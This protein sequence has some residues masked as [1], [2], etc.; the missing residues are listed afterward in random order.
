MTEYKLFDEIDLP[1]EVA[2]LLIAGMT[3]LITGGLLFPVASGVLPYYENGLYGLLLVIFALQIVTMGKT[4]FGDVRRSKL[5]IAGGVGVAAIGIVTC[6]IPGIPGQI[7]RGLLVLCFGPGSFLLLIQMLLAKAKL[8]TWITN[9]RLFRHLIFS[10][11]AV[12][13]LSILIALLIWQQTLLTTPATAAGSLIYGASIVYLAC[14]LRNI[15]GAYPAAE[16]PCKGEVDLSADQAVLMLMGIFMLLL[17]ILLIPVNLGLFPF[18]GS[19]QLGLLMVIFAVQML[20]SGST[21]IGPFPRSWLMVLFG[22]VFAAMG[23]VSCIIPEILVP[24]LTVFVGVLNVLGGIIPLAKTCI[25]RLRKSADLHEP[26][27]PVLTKLF[28]TQV[29][30]NLL[31]ILFGSSML[32]SQLIPG[33]VVGVILAANGVVLLY[34]VY[35]LT[36]LDGMQREAADMAGAP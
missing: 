5:L 17:G 10:C 35:I 16:K 19:A 18:S 21:P 2:V 4:P 8:Q 1:L 12:Y 32:V 23:I 22:L 14:V 6:F 3:M 29:T 33:L 13:V 20:A 30:L 15:Y 28:A 11:S 25:S 9:G 24:F 27:L 7:P 34:L 26:D 36:I 31:S